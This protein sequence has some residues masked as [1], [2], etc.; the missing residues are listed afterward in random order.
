MNKE[1]MLGIPFYCFYYPSEKHDKVKDDIYHL[2][3]KRNPQNW[4]WDEADDERLQDLPQFKDLFE[5][6]LIHT[7]RFVKS[8]GMFDSKSSFNGSMGS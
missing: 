8:Y 1:T 2:N 4:L 6:C 3:W 7:Y 5:F